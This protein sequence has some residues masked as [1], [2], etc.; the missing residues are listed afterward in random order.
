M[1]KNIPKEIIDERIKIITNNTLVIIS[2]FIDTKHKALFKCLVCGLTYRTK[3]NDVLNGHSCPACANMNQGKN[4]RLTNEQ[5]VEKAKSIHGNK[6]DYSNTK[7]INSRT[8]IEIICPI[9]GLFIQKPNAHLN[10]N[11]C[12]KCK[13][14]LLEKKIRLMLNVNNINYEYQ[15]RFDWLNGK[16]LDFY[17]PEYNVA[18]ECQGS[19]HFIENEFF[20]DSLNERVERDKN[21]FKQCNE[22]K[23]LIYYFSDK[24]IKYMFPDNYFSKIFTS[25][26]ALIK[27]IINEQKF[28]NIKHN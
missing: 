21:K 13:E 14:S 10:N 20:S 9:H 4:R 18:I 23:I 25:K 19:Q 15:K 28:T 24:E 7:Y 1:G 11:G 6:Y 26:T 22:H 2:D 12:P 16:S 17:L 3:V 8:K 5:F 27:T